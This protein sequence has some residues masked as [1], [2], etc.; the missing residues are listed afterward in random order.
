[1]RRRQDAWPGRRVRLIPRWFFGE[2]LAVELASALAEAAFLCG[3]ALRWNRYWLLAASSVWLTSAATT[4]GEMILHVD[5]WAFDLQQ[6]AAAGR[7]AALTGA[8]CP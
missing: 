1:M 6:L 4:L 7:G 2:H 3:M 8:A 5:D